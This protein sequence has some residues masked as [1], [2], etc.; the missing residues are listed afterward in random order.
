MKYPAVKD[1]QIAHSP[2]SDDAFMFY[3]LA[4]SKIKVPGFKFSHNLTDIE[5][6]NHKAINDAFYDVTAISFHAYPYMQDRYA[7][8]SCGGSMGEGYGPMLVA[9]RKVRIEDIPKLRI[10]VPGTLTTAF[11]ALRLFAPEL[12]TFVVPFDRIIASVTSGE[13]DAGLLIHEGQLT[14]GND[15]LHKILD[16]GQWWLTETGLPLP[17]GGNAIRRSLGP[18]TMLT[19]NQAVRDSIQFA[20]DHREAALDYAMQFA[21]DL[22]PNLANRYVG[23]YVNQRSIDYGEDG[24]KAIV[25]ILEM[26]HERGIIPIK[27]QVDFIG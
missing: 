25:R 4:T 12:Q 23:M 11:L 8:M 21:R 1:I 27:P 18:A 20:L 24:R 10:A 9:P 17:L 14:F 15:G 3:G 13:Y 7:L 16:L 2:D 6:L 5:T 26:G 19:T 22:D